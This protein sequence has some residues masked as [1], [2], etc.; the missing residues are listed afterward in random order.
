M[1]SKFSNVVRRMSSYME[2]RVPVSKRIGVKDEWL[3][4]YKLIFPALLL[5][6]LVHFLPSLWGFIISFMNVD[7]SYIS[8]WYDAPFVGLENYEMVLNPTTPVGEGYWYSVRQTIIFSV[9]SIIGSYLL[10]LLTALILNRKFRGH[11]VARTLV[12]L[13]YIA[14]AVVTLYVWRMMF[15]SETGIVN[16]LLFNL[17]LIENRK[18][19]WLAGDNSIWAML[20]ANIWRNFPF[21]ALML[22]AGLQSIPKQLYEAAQIDGAGTWAQF[23]YITFPQLK[24]VTAV[25]L[26]LMMLWSFIN[27]TTPFI[28]FGNSPAKSA[29]VLMIFIYNYAF[30]SY[31]FGLGAA[32]SVGLFVV[33]MFLALIYYKKF[34]TSEFEAAGGL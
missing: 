30:K 20:I 4:S 3:F 5:M 33:A 32:M 2:Q 18:I 1:G 14:P 28:L 12:L 13:P 9:G 16:W 24:P 17:G 8:H 7:A 19:L 21:A 34:V 31:D 27:F 23:R 11:L 29:R 22:Y 6:T 15:L 25:I 10:G 26:L